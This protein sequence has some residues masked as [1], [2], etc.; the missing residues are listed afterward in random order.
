MQ[1]ERIPICIFKTEENNS[2]AGLC[3]NKNICQ[4][5]DIFIFCLVVVH[6]FMAGLVRRISKIEMIILLLFTVELSSTTRNR[7]LAPRQCS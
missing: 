2:A 4:E 1:S 7:L 3:G 5:E 6:L